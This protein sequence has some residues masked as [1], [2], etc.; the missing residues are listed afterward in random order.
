MLVFPRFVLHINGKLTIRTIKEQGTNRREVQ[1]SQNPWECLLFVGKYTHQAQHINTI[2]QVTYT[3]NSYC[4]Y[5][6]QF[7]VTITNEGTYLIYLGQIQSNKNILQTNTFLTSYYKQ[8]VCHSILRSFQLA[9]LLLKYKLCLYQISI[10][11]K[12]SYS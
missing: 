11:D 10:L 3:L 12:C 2:V 6:F 4:F 7:S 1:L 8:L 5:F 9:N